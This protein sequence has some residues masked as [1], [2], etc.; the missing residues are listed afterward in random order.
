MTRKI[1]RVII[2]VIGAMVLCIAT[3]SLFV[4]LSGNHGFV[5]VAGE[6]GLVQSPLGGDILVKFCPDADIVVVPENVTVM[7]KSA[8]TITGITENK[9]T[10]ANRRVIL[11]DADGNTFFGILPPQAYFAVDV[12]KHEIKWFE[13][14]AHQKI[15]RNL[16]E[17][18][19]GRSVPIR[20]E[21]K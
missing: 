14:P 1:K 15:I 8:E 16:P 11:I 17:S 3:V 20:S 10:A 12:L 13:D 18:V 9:G 7:G 6:Y 2:L 19:T 21:I 5:V 4:K